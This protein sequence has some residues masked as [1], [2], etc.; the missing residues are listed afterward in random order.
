MISYFLFLFFCPYI[1][2]NDRNVIRFVLYK[3]RGSTLELLS[4]FHTYMFWI[5]DTHWSACMYMY[6]WSG[7]LCAGSLLRGS[8]WRETPWR[9]THH[10]VTA[11]E[12]GSVHP[13]GT[14][15][16][17]AKVLL[18]TAWKC[19]NFGLEMGCAYLTSPLGSVTEYSDSTTFLSVFLCVWRGGGGG[20]KNS[21][22]F[23]II[24]NHYVTGLWG[25]QI[26]H[27][28]QLCIGR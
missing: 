15:S 5:Y 14:H 24:A 12:A 23:T 1:L 17:F 20:G 10:L 19:K 2:N 4:I 26:D 7:Y 16:C 3:R 13:T 6:L 25:L 21:G 9:E 27:S 22:Q 18:K 8:P 28:I 11:T